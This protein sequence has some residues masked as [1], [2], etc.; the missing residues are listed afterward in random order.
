MALVRHCGGH[1]LIH[2]VALGFHHHLNELLQ[3]LRRRE[4]R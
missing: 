3:L 4:V 1:S 2:I